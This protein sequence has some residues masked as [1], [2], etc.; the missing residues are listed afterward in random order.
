MTV[1]LPEYNHPQLCKGI[2][3]RAKWL[4]RLPIKGTFYLTRKGASKR[5]QTT[6]YIQNI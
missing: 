4:L 2:H 3:L 5:L 1:T 6:I